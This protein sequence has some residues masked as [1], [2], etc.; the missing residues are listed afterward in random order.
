MRIAHVTATF[1]PYRAGTGNVCFDNARELARRGH[2][3]HV[4]T[5]TFDD[6]PVFEVLDGV[7][8]HRLR[9]L[10]RLGNAPVLP[11]LIPALRGFDIIHLHYPFIGGAEF[12]R[13]AALRYRI[14]LV[15]SFHNDLI[16]EGV[17]APLFTLYQQLSAHLSVRG[18][19]RLC[20]VSLD[21]YMSSR[22]AK[23]LPH[24]PGMV[25]ELPNSVNTCHFSPVGPVAELAERYCIPDDSPVV[26]F[27]AALDRAHYFKGLSHAMAAVSYLP[28]EV[29]LVVIGDGDLR[30]R[31]EQEAWELGI[32]HRTIFVGAVDHDDTPQF[33][34]RAAVT[35]LPS[36]EVES[37]GLVLIESM[38]CGTP[39]VASNIPGIRSVVDH[40]V[41]G[42]L[43]T[44][45][46][47][48]E[49]ARAI[50]L[51][52]ANEE[53][54]QLMGQ[55]GRRKVEARYAAARIG[56]R[57]DALYTT[58]LPYEPCYLHAPEHSRWEW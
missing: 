4:F 8:V 21:H 12:V 6:A 19:A 52:L 46:D 34:R 31:Y 5:A 14:P 25:V 22:L 28:S 18:A 40:G 13:L 55:R 48:L 15:V 50:E 1:P 29:R 38:A 26:L 36:S 9:P 37:F 11:G 33:F 7:S 43:V 58:V 32:A 54:R 45:G 51:T 57:L 39:V 27:I 10:I 35:V 53:H 3:V 16:G 30:A 44:P 56:Q 2:E 24:R 47:S 42:F 23:T 17:R 41:D 49:L 20:A